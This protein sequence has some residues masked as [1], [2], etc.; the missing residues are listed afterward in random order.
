MTIQPKITTLWLLAVLRELA[1]FIALVTTA[2]STLLMLSSSAVAAAASPSV[3]AAC[4]GPQGQGTSNGIPRLAGQN[5]GYLRN[6]LALF[7]SG[8]RTNPVMQSVAA[9]LSDADMRELADYF[10]KQRAPNVDVAVDV[11]KALV[12][13]GKQLAERGSAGV[14]ACF[15][16]HGAQGTGNGAHFPSIAG[17]PAKFLATRLHEFQARARA[18]AAESGTM[19]AVAAAM[20]EQQIQ[21]AA[22]YLSKTDP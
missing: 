21:Q 4:H 18:H 8:D 5:A 13:S 20:S 12:R 3:C 15:S 22:A 11:P 17:Q 14:A 19:T 6:A 10:S 9:S 2:C 7:K 1:R 16:C